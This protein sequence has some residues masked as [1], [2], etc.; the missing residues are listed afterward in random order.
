MRLPIRY[1]VQ[2]GCVTLKDN[3]KN[4]KQKNWNVLRVENWRTGK[5]TT[6]KPT[7][8]D[9]LKTRCSFIGVSTTVSST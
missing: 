9:S 2:R 1:A 6:K 8:L 7:V 3:V 4:G 5:L